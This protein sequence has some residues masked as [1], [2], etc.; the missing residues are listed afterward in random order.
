MQNNQG[1]GFSLQVGETGQSS[2]EILAAHRASVAQDTTPKNASVAPVKPA[3]KLPPVNSEQKVENPS[4]EPAEKVEVLKK[5]LDAQTASA[6]NEGNK[7]NG[8]MKV[9][10]ES[11]GVD[12]ESILARLEETN[13]TLYAEAKR[14]LSK[15]LQKSGESNI[16]D[17]LLN[18]A[19]RELAV[20]RKVELIEFSKEYKLSADE[21]TEIEERAQDLLKLNPSM[22]W[23]KAMKTALNLDFPDKTV[24][25]V[26]PTR[27]DVRNDSAPIIQEQNRTGFSKEESEAIKNLEKKGGKNITRNPDGTMTMSL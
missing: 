14:R 9:V 19:D 11:E 26:A 16:V 10:L 1:S 17:K 21:Q 23:N 24:Q 8:L 4:T 3:E 2:E 5:Q 18:A 25:F 20:E 6:R 22:R 7:F 12:R 15:E 27:A 13:P